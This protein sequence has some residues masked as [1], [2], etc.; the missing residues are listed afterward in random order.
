MNKLFLL[1]ASM[2]ATTLLLTACSDEAS[3]TDNNDSS[4]SAA[5]F[6]NMTFATK[7]RV[8]KC[9]NDYFDSTEKPNAEVIDQC[10]G[11]DFGTIAINTIHHDPQGGKLVLTDD[12]YNDLLNAAKVTKTPATNNVPATTPTQNLQD[13][14]PKT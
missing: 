13:N 12:V 10:L 1:T 5:H 7:G 3:V 6:S 14:T 4:G 9:V 2:L 8:V 11:S